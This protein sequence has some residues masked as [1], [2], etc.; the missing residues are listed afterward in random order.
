M[1]WFIDSIL[2]N[3]SKFADALVLEDLGQNQDVSGLR[4]FGYNNYISG[5][6]EFVE[7]RGRGLLQQLS[8]RE[9]GGAEVYAA[10]AQAA[11]GDVLTAQ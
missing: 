1:D 11:G 3:P 7:R 8:Q 2:L 9:N 6:V 5:G 4:P 10:P